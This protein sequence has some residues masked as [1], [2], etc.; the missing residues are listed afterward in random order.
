MVWKKT[1]P[2]RSAS[3]VI[4]SRVTSLNTT[5]PARIPPLSVS[6]SA[7]IASARSRRGDRQ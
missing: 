6:V 3:A 5:L 1:G 4:M 2:S 7:S